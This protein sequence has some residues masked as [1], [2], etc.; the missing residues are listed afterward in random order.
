VS[1]TC[2]SRQTFGRLHRRINRDLNGGTSVSGN[3]L[4]T[5]DDV[6]GVDN[7]NDYYDPSLK[8]ARLARL[9]PHPRFTLVRLDLADSEGTARLF[10]VRVRGEQQAPI[11]RGGPGRSPGEPGRRHEEGE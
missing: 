8:E 5:C 2:G 10:V 3:A 9:I 4:G 6:I 7:L 11:Q 1:C